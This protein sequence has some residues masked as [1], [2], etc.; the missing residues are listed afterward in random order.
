[1]TQTAQT[2]QGSSTETL[3]AAFS[4]GVQQGANPAPAAAVPAPVA[5]HSGNDLGNAYDAGVQ[6]GAN[7]TQQTTAS[8]STTSTNGVANVARAAGDK[9][10]DGANVIAG[11]IQNPGA[12][13]STVVD[14]TKSFFG[15]LDI[16]KIL[17][18]ILGLGGA[19][20]LGSFFGSGIMST[21]LMIGLA[22]PLM[23]IGSDKLGGMINGWVGRKSSDA[24]QTQ[25]APQVGGPQNV[26]SQAQ[27]QGAVAP[28]QVL[29]NEELV[30]MLDATHHRLQ[31]ATDPND[32]THAVH[33]R[34]VADTMAATPGMLDQATI[35]KIEAQIPNASGIA[36]FANARGGLDVQALP[37]R[38]AA[39]VQR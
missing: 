27:A 23:I 21:I 17:G 36:F 32:P 31:V 34:A 19:W 11:I 5:D 28:A 15:N 16:G 10:N 12:T 4:S 39:P 29:K 1:M 26:I 37:P 25:V 3:G 7:P 2:P 9:A 18:G 14:K 24:P 38:Q 13:V 20:F 6:Q 30:A 22:I 35:Q 33:V 8:T